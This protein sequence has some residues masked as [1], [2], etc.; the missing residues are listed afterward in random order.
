MSNTLKLCLTRSQLVFRSLSTSS[1][2]HSQPRV[3]LIKFLGKREK[4][5]PV[6]QPDPH[7]DTVRTN[8]ASAPQGTKPVAAA[9][10][11]APDSPSLSVTAAPG[12]KSKIPVVKKAT[13]PHTPNALDY[14]QLKDKVWH[15]RLKL[16]PEEM[17]AI[18]SGGAGIV[19]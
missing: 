19:N 12:P 18:D 3:P 15:G 8:P 5:R 10:F 16:S 4:G 13:K 7:H 17:S 9:P 14:S 11:A 1:H 2:A 6:S